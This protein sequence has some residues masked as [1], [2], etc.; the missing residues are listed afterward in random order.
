MQSG[1]VPLAAA[2][3]MPAE[4]DT[5]TNMLGLCLAAVLARQNQ[6]IQ[7]VLTEQCPRLITEQVVVNKIK[8]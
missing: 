4:A 2:S 8:K 3:G 6:L 5:K 7:A 1:Q